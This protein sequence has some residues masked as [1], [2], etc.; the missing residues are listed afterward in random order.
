MQYGDTRAAGSAALRA[1]AAARDRGVQPG[2][3]AY[4]LVYAQKRPAIVQSQV[5]ARASTSSLPGMRLCFVPFLQQQA[6]KKVAANG[7]PHAHC[8]LPVLHYV[9]PL[10]IEAKSYHCLYKIIVTFLGFF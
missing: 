1:R 6:E 3:R 7:Q 8:N 4:V 5:P 10:W 2:G 9:T